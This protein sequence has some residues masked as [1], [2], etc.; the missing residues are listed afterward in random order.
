MNNQRPI[1]R[2]PYTEVEGTTMDQRLKIYEEDKQE[3]ARVR[4]EERFNAPTTIDTIMTFL[5]RTKKFVLSNM[6][7]R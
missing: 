1:I 7:K 4:E 3:Y 6:K 5:E 2:D